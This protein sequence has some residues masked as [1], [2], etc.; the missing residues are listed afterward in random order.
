M[1]LLFFLTGGD[2]YV[3]L[4]YL[5]KNSQVAISCVIP[6]VCE[7]LV[8][9]VKDYIQVRQ[10]FLF[11]VYERNFKLDCNQNFNLNTTFTETF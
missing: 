10:I 4:Q 11:I 7:P 9:K 3:S 6:E 1:T 8:E 5:Y 2:S